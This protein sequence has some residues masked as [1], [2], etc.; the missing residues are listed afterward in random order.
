[1]TCAGSGA[2]RE[3]SVGMLVK[4]RSLAQPGLLLAGQLSA[5]PSPCYKAGQWPEVLLRATAP[6]I[7]ACNPVRSPPQGEAVWIFHWIMNCVQICC[8]WGSGR[9]VPQGRKPLGSPDQLHIVHMG[10]IKSRVQKSLH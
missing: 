4:H 8:T 2:V 5:A 7:S 1:M 10:S 9:L 6:P 3:G